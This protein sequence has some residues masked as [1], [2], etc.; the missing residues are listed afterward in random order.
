MPPATRARS[1]PRVRTPDPPAAPP[2]TALAGII[3]CGGKGSRMGR[4]R[5]H[6]VCVPLAGRPAVVRLID[7]LRAD[8]VSP[9]VVVVG[10]RAG[11]V[12]Q[13][14][15]A[16]HPG[17]Q[18]VYQ[19]DQLGTGHAARVGVEALRAFGCDGPV[20]ITMGDKWF[21]PG[22][23]RHA[24]RRYR[25]AGARLLVVSTPKRPDSAA[26]RLVRL[27]RRGICGNVEKRDIDRARILA[28][29]LAAAND[30]TTVPKARLRAIGLQRIRPQRKLWRALGPLARFARGAGTIQGSDVVHAIREVGTSIRV[31]GAS[32]PPD[33]VE[34]LATTVNQSVYVA[35]AAAV[36]LALRRVGRANAQDEYYLTDIIEIMARHD[37]PSDAAADRV[38][39]RAVVEYALRHSDDVMAF[40]NRTE[41]G[42]I[43]QRILA[44]EQRD[45]RHTGLDRTA[46][47]YL[48]R[49]D[50]WMSHLQPDSGRARRMIER[51]YGVGG[52]L[53]AERLRAIRRV[54]RL[55]ARVYGPQRR[56]LLARAPGRINLMGRHVDHQGGF[57]HAVALDREVLFAAAPRNDDVIRLINTDPV[58]FP[59][60]ELVLGDWRHALTGDW[61][62]FI[63]SDAVRAHLSSSAGD[64]SNYVLAAALFLRHRR[65]HAPWR[66][67]DVAVHGDVPMA[68]GLSSSSAMV[69]AAME[70]LALANGVRV[71]GEELVTWCGQA[72][73][74][75][76]SRGGSS[77]H[78][79]IR[80]GRAGHAA[81]MEFH[82]FRL[83]RYVR[84]PDGA[85]VI[86]AHSGEH[87]VKSA[88]ARDRF[89]ERVANY[90]L[91]VLWLK[92]FGP[93][94]VANIEHIRDLLPSRLRMDAS[95]VLTL[96]RSLPARRTRA[97]LRREL[98]P[99]FAEA[100]DRIFATHA[101]P[102]A[103]TIRDVVA[104]GVGECERSRVAAT[105]LDRGELD[106]FGRLMRISH[107]G[108]RVAGASAKP[109]LPDGD[110]A[111]WEMPGA[112]ACSTPNIDRLVDLAC[113]VPGVYGAQLAG[114]GLGGCVMI[115][116]EEAAVRRVRRTLTEHY[117][118]PTGMA[119]AVWAVRCVSGGGLI[120]P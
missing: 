62:R 108:D 33:R 86:I 45:A 14:V 104:F 50:E 58:A 43:E 70:A 74:F 37:A 112:Y 91:G 19:R 97:E 101:E 107:D 75:V 111:L 114:A 31:A 28:D 10:H 117:Y 16:A 113:G 6:K 89:N 18:F 94:A 56:L 29:W 2:D 110:H 119:P 78:A 40:N 76:G 38:A 35:D 100:L 103:Y 93:K 95:D 69:V 22:L 68:A 46:A 23:V 53:V 49:C 9:I 92:R 52:A 88:G 41:L 105:Y 63:D 90:R 98:G 34:R 115:L 15:G 42:R 54:L 17:V 106:T 83:A 80:L 102:P 57:V 67:I 118:R 61:L 81:R 32:L 11:D 3:L 7:T 84:I 71:S 79:A 96:V 27:P 109:L 99:R 73:W 82:P 20:L 72:E 65:P 13:T 21:E 36:H 5:V 87:A 24:L 12:V 59:P 30:A 4:T 48:R 1:T 66:G 39:H 64:W 116:A 8:G 60:R 120:R 44:L 26:G 25:D 55:F 51:T 47:R 77:D 85:A